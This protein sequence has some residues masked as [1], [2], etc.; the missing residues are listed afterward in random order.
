MKVR[1]KRTF[2]FLYLLRWFYFYLK[3]KTQ[4]RGRVQLEIGWCIVGVSGN[5]EIGW[6]IVG[7]SGNWAESSL[8]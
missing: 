2:L 6:C 1:E 3:N 4:M 8:A 7:V 5:W